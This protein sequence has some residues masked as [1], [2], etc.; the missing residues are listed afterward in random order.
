MDE[1]NGETSGIQ[2]V[3]SAAQVGPGS[4]CASAAAAVYAVPSCAMT[5]SWA[6][7]PVVV[8]CVLA[9]VG[10]WVATVALF[11]SPLLRWHVLAVTAS[12]VLT[13]VAFMYGVPFV[14]SSDPDYGKVLPYMSG[15]V[16]AIMTL[17]LTVGLLF[18]VTT[19]ISRRRR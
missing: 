2:A 16:Q 15:M 18:R 3:P 11:R 12:S 8:G 5:F 13:A 7:P 9:G 19:R 17:S 10:L 4:G 6:T 14:S 1:I